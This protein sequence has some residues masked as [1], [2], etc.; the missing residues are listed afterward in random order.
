MAID[1]LH[2]LGPSTAMR[3]PARAAKLVLGMALDRLADHY[4]N[5][6]G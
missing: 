6:N 2:M 3:W 5:H 4:M 1:A